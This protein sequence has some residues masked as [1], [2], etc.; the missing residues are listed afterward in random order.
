MENDEDVELEFS[1]NYEL[2]GGSM[3]HGIEVRKNKDTFVMYHISEAMIFTLKS[4]FTYISMIHYYFTKCS[5]F[6]I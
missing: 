1:V 3:I 5:T 4:T 6:I 2:D